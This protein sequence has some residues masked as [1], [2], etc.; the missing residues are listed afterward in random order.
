MEGGDDLEFAY[1]AEELLSEV[2]I[3][4]LGGEFVDF[5]GVAVGEAD[6]VLGLVGEGFGGADSN[7]VEVSPFG[8]E[9]VGLVEVVLKHWNRL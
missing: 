3:G 4:G 7:G 8:S 9:L 6:E 2:E 5:D 1:V